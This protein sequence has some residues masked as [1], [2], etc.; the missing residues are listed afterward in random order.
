MF[1]ELFYVLVVLVDLAV[2]FDALW[3]WLIV[4]VVVAF[5]A[6]V[7]FDGHFELELDFAVCWLKL[8]RGFIDDVSCYA[9][10][11]PTL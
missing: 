2:G 4:E 7:A 5:E 3:P 9:E 10:V 6:L 8:E 11:A 1:F